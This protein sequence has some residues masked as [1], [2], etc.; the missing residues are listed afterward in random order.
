MCYSNLNVIYAP[1]YFFKK[2]LSLNIYF[3]LIFSLLLL[4][5][6]P[7]FALCKRIYNFVYSKETPAFAIVSSVII[8]SSKIRH[9][10]DI[11]KNIL[12][13]SA[14]VPLFD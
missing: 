8:V 2:M 4:H 13:Y 7:V 14:I 10:F 3:F 5:G 1:S 12:S 9:K 6:F 11:Q